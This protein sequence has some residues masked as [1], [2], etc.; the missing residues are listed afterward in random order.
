[1]TPCSAA[2]N[3]VPT[4]QVPDSCARAVFALVA[5]LFAQYDWS[6]ARQR[7]MVVLKCPAPTPMVRAMRALH[8]AGYRLIVSDAG[9]LAII[10]IGRRRHTDRGPRDGTVVER[11]TSVPNIY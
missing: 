3:A 9:A 10:V 4:T 1:M 7:H 11:G 6:W 2:E 8:G 5:P